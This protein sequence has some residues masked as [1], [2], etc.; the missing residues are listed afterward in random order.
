MRPNTLKIY[1][2]ELNKAP[3]I[4][5]WQ[6]PF[7]VRRDRSWGKTNYGKAACGRVSSHHRAWALGHSQPHPYVISTSRAEPCRAHLLNRKIQSP[8]A[9]SASYLQ[10]TGGEIVIARTAPIAKKRRIPNLRS[11]GWQNLCMRHNFENVFFYTV[12]IYLFCFAYIGTTWRSALSRPLVAGP[13]SPERSKKPTE[14]SSISLQKLFYYIPSKCSTLCT[15]TG[16]LHV[17][18]VLE[19]SVARKTHPPYFNINSSFR[20]LHYTIDIYLTILVNTYRRYIYM[21]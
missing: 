9:S 5:L 10:K 4:K 8:F 12:E 20:C 7:I 6:G 18:D 17:S 3:Q 14:L 11:W 1:R 2:K 13:T 15:W 19:V 21:R 16:L